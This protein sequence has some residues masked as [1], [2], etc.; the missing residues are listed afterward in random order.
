MAR[1]A[2][3]WEG[4]AVADKSEALADLQ[5]RYDAFRSRIAELPAHAYDETWLGSWNL[6]QLLAHMSGWYREMAE[7]I[8]RVAAGQPPAPAG[9]D[10][11]DSD[12]W[13]AKFVQH[14]IQ[15]PRHSR[16]GMP[17]S[18][19]I[20]MLPPRS[21]ANSS[22][23]NPVKNRPKIGN[24]LLHGAGIG[25]FEEHQPELDAWLASRRSG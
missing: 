25:H 23:W 5:S 2:Q 9:V 10:Y 22:A 8:G 7:A 24:R 4:K 14:T 11:G 17:H 19:R 3:A 12:T 20:G 21:T 6:S 1:I 16:I 13:N 18:P 15:A